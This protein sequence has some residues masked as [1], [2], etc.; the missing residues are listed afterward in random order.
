MRKQ[1]P[2]RWGAYLADEL[3]KLLQ[4]RHPSAIAAVIVDP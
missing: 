4:I 3:T 1:S 2:S